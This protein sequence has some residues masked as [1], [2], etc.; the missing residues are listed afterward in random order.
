MTDINYT[1]EASFPPS[2]RPALQALVAE[3]AADAAESKE[4]A[5]ASTD[6]LVTAATVKDGLEWSAS[7]LR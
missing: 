1:T 3:A 2:L 6:E 5:A 4:L 7:I